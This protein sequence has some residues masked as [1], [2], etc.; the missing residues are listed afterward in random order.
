MKF[1]TFV[2]VVK[3]ISKTKFEVR[4]SMGWPVMGRRKWVDFRV[5][6]V[7]LLTFS[8][9]THSFI[10]LECWVIAHFKG[11]LKL[12]SNH[13]NQSHVGRYLNLIIVTQHGPT[14]PWPGKKV[15][16]QISIFFARIHSA[17]TVQHLCKKSGWATHGLQRKCK[18]CNITVGSFHV[19]WTNI[20]KVCT[21]TISENSKKITRCDAMYL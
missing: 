5:E 1:G 10:E 9:I 2:Y 20:N 18:F 7:H 8:S 12:A 3:R 15:Y 6:V 19:K 17:Y 13:I 4:G 16:Q 21:L 14:W 11:S